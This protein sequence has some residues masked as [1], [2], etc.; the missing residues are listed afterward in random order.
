[1]RSLNEVVF[2]GWPAY[3]LQQGELTL[4]VV[5]SVGGRLMGIR[6]DDRELCFVHPDLEGKS[7]NG[8]L[9][10]W[11]LLRGDWSFPLWGGGKTWVAPESDWPDGIPHSDLDSLAW[12]V[13]KVWSDCN[14]MGIALSSPVCRSS[15]L[16]ISRTISLLSGGDAWRI[17]HVLSN[18][19]TK[20]IRCGIWDVLML[21]QPARLTIPL[22]EVTEPVLALPGHPATATLIEEG[23]LSFSKGTAEVRCV[24]PGKFKCGFA[25]SN[26]VVQVD[27][28]QWGIRYERNSRMGA[29]NEYAHGRPVEIFNAPHLPYFEVETHSPAV[30]L[31]S[32]ESTHYA[33]EERTLRY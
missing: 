23:K 20:E 14:S 17:E 9:E 32:G 4:H 2:K 28:L 33:I 30:I 10:E 19:G 24:R 5:P 16:Q 6:F 22:D 15:G 25:S 3:S 26:G 12:Q 11:E 1:M 8:S 31:A 21:N 27:F 29:E 7:F 18:R 13:I